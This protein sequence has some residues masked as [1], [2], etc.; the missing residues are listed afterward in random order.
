[1][2]LI[3]LYL[4]WL[5]LKYESFFNR[6]ICSSLLGSSF[7]T[8]CVV[9]FSCSVLSVL[10]VL[11]NITPLFV[12]SSV[13]FLYTFFIFR[14]SL[15]ISGFLVAFFQFLLLLFHSVRG[16]L[17]CFWLFCRLCRSLF[18]RIV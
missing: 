5:L 17:V 7:V 8:S 9:S 15:C 18:L 11:L 4:K 1:M 12:W 13:S 2:P 14:L 16:F 3:M 10:N 6:V